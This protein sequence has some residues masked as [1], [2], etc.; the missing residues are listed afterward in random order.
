ML[1][2]GRPRT[3]ENKGGQRVVPREGII[4]NHQH[5]EPLFVLSMVA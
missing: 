5:D 4:R 3:G 2:N 1:G